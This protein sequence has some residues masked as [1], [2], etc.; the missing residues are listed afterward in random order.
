MKVTVS[1]GGT[2]HAFRLAEQLSARGMLHRLVTTHQPLRGERIPRERIVAN[3]WPEALMRGPRM[4]GLRWQAGDYLK[5]VAFDRWAVRYAGGSDVWVGFAAFS[6]ASQRAAQAA[7]ART[8]LER[9]S[10][11]ILTQYALIAEEYRRWRYPAPPVDR[12]L[13][14]RQLREYDEAEHIS[15]PSRFALE[16]F[17]D[18]GFPAARLLSIPYGADTRFFSP[19]PPP[20]RPFRIITVG[21]SLRKGTPYL[22]EA[23]SRLGL[24]GGRGGPDMEICLA[25]AVAPD[26]AA[27]LRETP[28]PVRLLGA[29]S[30]AELAPVYRSASVFVLPSVEE[31]MALSV[32]EAL[33]SG[34]PVVAT[35]NT[36]AADIITHGHEG[37]IV[38]VR[39]AAALAEALLELYEDES[40]RRA[41]AEAAAET[42]GKWT[43]DAYGDRVAA[44]YT[45]LMTPSAT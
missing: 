6:L 21:L 19:G 2:F 45:G 35:P 22:L 13:V 15:V 25:G 14:D 29:L 18:R 38:P 32:L 12:R 20:S 11:H 24:T 17:L 34:L 27:V 23:A 37:L 8:V 39:D 43:W 36:G 7:G 16:S 42:A 9:G 40:K 10:T 33:A 30:H 3:P 44:A 31:G 26:V 4:L 5:T 28:V 1:V 41:M